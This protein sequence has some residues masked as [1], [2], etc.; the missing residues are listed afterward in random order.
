MPQIWIGAL[1]VKNVDAIFAGIR[2]GDRKNGFFDKTAAMCK[3]CPGQSGHAKST[4]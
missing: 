3:L 1:T 4:T 2:G